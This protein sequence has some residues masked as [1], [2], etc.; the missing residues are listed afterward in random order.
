M[1]T[2][3]VQIDQLAIEGGFAKEQ[4]RDL[5]SPNSPFSGDPFTYLPNNAADPLKLV[6]PSW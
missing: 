2:V 4:E 1:Q 5:Q 6:R 3:S